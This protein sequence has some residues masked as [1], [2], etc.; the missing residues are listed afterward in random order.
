MCAG[1]TVTCELGANVR[2]NAYDDCRRM[3]AHLLPRGAFGFGALWVH[4]DALSLDPSSSFFHP[5][6]GGRNGYSLLVLDMLDE[7]APCGF[8]DCIQNVT[9]LTAQWW[10]VMACTRTRANAH[11]AVCSADNAHPCA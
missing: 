1:H 3:V 6:E 4:H 8:V 7:L 5:Q 2:V 10:R 9:S 11:G